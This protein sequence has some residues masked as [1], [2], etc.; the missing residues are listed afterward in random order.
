VAPQ[1]ADHTR[2]G[3]WFCQGPHHLHGAVSSFALNLPSKRTKNT[4]KIIFSQ[5][6][7]RKEWGE[8]TSCPINRTATGGRENQVRDWVCLPHSRQC[9]TRFLTHGQIDSTMSLGGG[10]VEKS[11][12]NSRTWKTPA[13]CG[14]LGAAR[15][16]K[17]RL[18]QERWDKEHMK[19]ASCRLTAA[20]NARFKK[21]C[22]AAGATRYAVIRYMISVF[23]YG[24]EREAG[25]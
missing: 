23:C 19:T 12:E 8:R 22:K 2:W 18:R 25:I 6:A 10:I 24:V 16:G 7:E 17:G 4:E 9:A 13:Q 11:V 3:S 5:R 14:A 1:S 20:E 21:C 15:A